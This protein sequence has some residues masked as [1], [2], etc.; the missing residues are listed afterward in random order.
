MENL[1][2]VN[3]KNQKEKEETE[4]QAQF[5]RQIFSICTGDT[6]HTS[7]QKKKIFLLGVM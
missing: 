4:K 7:C 1:F 2:V 3:A 6:G 5:N